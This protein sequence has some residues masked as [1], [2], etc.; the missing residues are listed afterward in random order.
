[1][2]EPQDHEGVHVSV[3]EAREDFAE[4]VNRAA[5]KEERVIITR[6]G[7]AIAAIVPIDDVAYLERLE[8]DYDL[9]EALRVLNDPDEMANTIPWEQ[10]KNELRS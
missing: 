2:Y 7:R 5:Y 8:D 4:L 10:V 1:M 6:R 3:T 9:Q